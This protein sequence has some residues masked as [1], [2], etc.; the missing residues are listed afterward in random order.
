MSIFETR[1]SFV[2]ASELKD[3]KDAG[4]I[5]DRTMKTLATFKHTHSWK[6]PSG[7]PGPLGPLSFPPEAKTTDIQIEAVD[8][9][10]IGEIHEFPPPMGSFRL[11]RTWEIYNDKRELVGIVK[12]KPKFVGADWVLQNPNGAVIATIEG[13][14]KKKDFRI[15]SSKNQIVASCYVD[16]G[17]GEGL[18]RLDIMGVD[19]DSF[20]V[21]SYVI[22]LEHVKRG[23]TYRGGD[24][25]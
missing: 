1:K 4:S 21:L 17:I 14:R 24:T 10:L 8:H 13:D 25:S 2:I 6:V 7:Y 5:M 11:I 16:Q 23:W 3:L 20:L 19:I 22:V 18:Y 9:S 15:L 12:E